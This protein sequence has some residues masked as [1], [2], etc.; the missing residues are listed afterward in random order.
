LHRGDRVALDHV[1]PVQQGRVV[2]PRRA[3]FAPSGPAAVASCPARHGRP[4]TWAS[5]P[6]PTGVPPA[7]QPGPARTSAASRGRCGHRSCAT[8]QAGSRSRTGC[9]GGA[10]TAGSSGRFIC[11]PDVGSFWVKRELA[12][13][14]DRRGDLRLR[15]H[16]RHAAQSAGGTCLPREVRVRLSGGRRERAGALADG[17]FHAGLRARQPNESPES[18]R[19]PV[20]ERDPSHRARGWPPT[21]EEQ[22]AAQLPIARRD[23]AVDSSGAVAAVGTSRGS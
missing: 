9:T 12:R 5:E 11:S 2:A 14:G 8:A 17:E 10:P 18:Q 20:I 4:L 15:H 1:V 23:V 21:D 3:P 19:A 13:G 16:P 7:V 22:A 6:S